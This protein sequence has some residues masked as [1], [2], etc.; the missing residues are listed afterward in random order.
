MC[1]EGHTRGSGVKSGRCARAGVKVLACS[2]SELL[3]GGVGLGL[4]ESG[5][6][7]LMRSYTCEEFVKEV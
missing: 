7:M 5:K 4:A 3:L 1:R 6:W 2:G